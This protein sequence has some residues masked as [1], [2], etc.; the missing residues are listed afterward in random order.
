MTGPLSP[1]LLA[2][3]PLA[4]GLSLAAITAALARRAVADVPP[5]GRFIDLPHARL[6]VVD[7]GPLAH[8]GAPAIVLLHGLGGQLRH[9]SYRLIGEL[10]PDYRVIAF[11]RPGSG[12]SSWQAGVIPSLAAQAD[13]VDALAAELQIERMILVGHSLGGAIALG[14]ALRQ[15]ARIAALALL[16]PL[17]HAPVAVSRRTVKALRV[18]DGLW[19]ALAWTVAVP[20]ARLQRER[21]LAQIFAPDP[22][23]PDFL[24]DG[25]GALL[26]RPGH[27]L[28][29]AR[30]LIDIPSWMEAITPRY[31]ELNSRSTLPIE[32]LFGRQDQ[33]LSAAVQG[34]RFAQTVGHARLHQIDAGHMLPMTCPVQCAEMIRR[35]ADATSR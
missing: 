15:P 17:T 2:L 16:A 13:L 8:R 1:S 30:D 34:E 6:H 3:A 18:A 20:V 32:V 21:R 14:A 24:S 29:A 26:L 10:S 22:V 27:V 5:L 11:D 4:A 28:A 19:R 33:V 9:F 7:S 31:P 12:Y 23:P 35:V 25:G